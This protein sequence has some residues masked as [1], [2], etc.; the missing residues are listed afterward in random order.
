M[1][2][3][4]TL[5]A[6]LGLDGVYVDKVDLLASLIN[7]ECSICDRDEMYLIGSTVLNRVDNKNFPNTIKKVIYQ[8]NQY[9]GASSRNFYKTGLTV[10]VAKNLLAGRNRECTVLY[11]YARDGPE[12]KFIKKI[13]KKIKYSKKFHNFA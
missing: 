1:I 3:I 11:F 2:K 7:S 6:L 4:L 5:I 10:E 9:K 13:K 12:N 8:R